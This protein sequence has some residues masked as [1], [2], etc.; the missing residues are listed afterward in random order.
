MFV[1]GQVDNSNSLFTYKEGEDVS[2]FVNPSFKPMFIEDIN[3]GN[4][5]LR[6]QAEA[7]CKGDISCLFDAASTG[8]LSIGLSTQQIGSQLVNDSNRMSKNW[9]NMR[10]LIWRENLAPKP[11]ARAFTFRLRSVSLA[12]KFRAKTCVP[13]KS[14]LWRFTFLLI[15]SSGNKAPIFSNTSSVIYLNVN[16]TVTVLINATDDDGDEITFNVSGLADSTI[17]TNSRTS[18][19]LTW[20]VTMEKVHE[21]KK[22]TF[23]CLKCMRSRSEAHGFHSNSSFF[24]LVH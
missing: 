2:T 4:D 13:K 21:N 7:A 9:S 10:I 20:K 15:V 16:T 22:N 18:V 19:S 14:F 3:W 11:V 12:G 6:L 8:D 17:Q 5:S 1:L 23:A 24:L